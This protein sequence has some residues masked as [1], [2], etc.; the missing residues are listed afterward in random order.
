MQSPRE[1]ILKYFLQLIFQLIFIENLKKQ[2]LKNSIKQ[3]FA[4]E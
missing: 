1:M 4:W 2:F 3:H